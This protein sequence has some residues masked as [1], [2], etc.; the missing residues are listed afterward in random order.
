MRF[1][2]LSKKVQAVL[3]V[4]YTWCPLQLS[5]GKYIQASEGTL[6]PKSWY[7]EKNDR[8]MLN[9]IFTSTTKKAAT[10]F[11]EKP[12]LT[13]SGDPRL[14]TP[15]KH[16]WEEA[17]NHDILV[18]IHH[19][20]CTISTVFMIFWH[21]LNVTLFSTRSNHPVIDDSNFSRTPI[22]KSM[23]ICVLLDL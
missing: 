23:V 20:T 2:S 16:F 1:V 17:P 21:F 15:M 19:T 10:L 12:P 11:P 4:F 7:P 6:C 18:P 8:N 3:N 22:H 9:Y 5:A 14:V 13:F